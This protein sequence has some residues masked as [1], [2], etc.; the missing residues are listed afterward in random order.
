MKGNIGVH[1]EDIGYAVTDKKKYLTNLYNAGY[2]KIAATGRGTFTEYEE[3]KQ[4][5][6]ELED[7]KGMK[8][9]I[10]PAIRCFYKTPDDTLV[11][12]AKDYEGYLSLCRII[13]ESNALGTVIEHPKKENTAD[14]PIVHLENLRKNVA[15]GHLF[16]TTSGADG[17]IPRLLGKKSRLERRLSQLE[18]HL[19]HIKI[20]DEVEASY[21]DCIDL[22]SYYNNLSTVKRPLKKEIEAATKFFEKTGNREDL[23]DLESRMEEYTNASRYKKLLSDTIKQV[24]KAIKPYKK[25]YT[26]YI[27]LKSELED[28]TNENPLLQAKEEFEELEEIFGKEDTL[29]ELQYHNTEEEKEVL[30]QMINFGNFFVDNRIIIMNYCALM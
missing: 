3:V 24:K 22:L 19:H 5:A 14:K 9:E 4:I 2:T 28:V 18:Q 27:D 25:E 16:V 12:I 29:I 26:E 11:L 20:G 23:D 15:K 30:H 10:I 7:K 1:F 6:K 17:R 21:E 8:M 13:T